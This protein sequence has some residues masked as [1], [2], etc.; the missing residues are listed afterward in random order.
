MGLAACIRRRDYQEA[1]NGTGMAAEKAIGHSLRQLAYFAL[2]GSGPEKEMPQKLAD[3]ASAQAQ[4][5]WRNWS[6]F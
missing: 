1:A 3:E 6:A 5:I 4:M 2:Y